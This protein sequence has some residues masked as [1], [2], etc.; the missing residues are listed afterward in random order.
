MGETGGGEAEEKALRL[1]VNRLLHR[2][3][4]TLKEMASKSGH[5]GEVAGDW[6][7]AE[8]VIKHLYGLDEDKK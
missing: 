5:K 8:N 7:M 1:L 6:Q 3:T 4:E 2:P